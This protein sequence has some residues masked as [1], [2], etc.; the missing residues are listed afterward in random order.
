MMNGV[1]I[2]SGDGLS[3]VW[4]Q[5]IIQ[6]K[7]DLLLIGSLGTNFG[8]IVLKIWQIYFEN[9]CLLQYV[10]LFRTKTLCYK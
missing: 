2:V 6:S 10:I 5:A 9:V 8:E 4:Y 7:G 3:H 1:I